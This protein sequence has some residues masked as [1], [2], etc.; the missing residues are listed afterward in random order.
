[1][2]KLSIP[3]LARTAFT[4]LACLLFLP[5]QAPASPLVMGLASTDS[6]ESLLKDWQPILDDL[7]T[8]L[9]RQVEAMIL[10]DYAGVIW[11]M[12]T[13]RAQIAWLGNKAA[14]E[15][16]DR[17]GAEVLVQT[18]NKY[19]PGYRAHLITRRE[20]PW[21]CEEDVLAH[22]AEIEFGIGDPNST[23]GYT[24]PSYY[25]FAAEGIDP[26]KAFKRL[27]HHNH[28]ENFLAVASGELDVATSNSQALSRFKTRFPA[29][30][31][32]IKII[33]TSP[34]IPSDPILVRSD[35]DPALKA[36]I[37]AFF[38]GYAKPG[39]G[40]SE[41]DVRRETANLAARSW[42]GFQGSDN[43]QLEPVRKLE[44]YKRRLQLE[45]DESLSETEKLDR[46]QKIDAAITGLD[47]E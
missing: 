43:S 39:P 12:A 2:K 32:R 31:Q 45:R 33:W 14:I 37:R 16:V 41:A 27:V 46:L 20:A 4:V 25:L 40:K 38:L 21:T 28:E 47:E 11:Y 13:G 19:G 8:A 29:R 36:D 35:L 9:N 26:N 1:M 5:W 30:Y 44:F 6:R 7:S 23:S 15:A 34:L 24:V 42:T 18:R 22:S 3:G 17:A 10:D